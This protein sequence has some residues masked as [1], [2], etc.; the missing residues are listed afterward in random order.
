MSRIGLKTG[1][2]IVLAVLVFCWLIKTPVTAHYWGKRIGI[3]VLLGRVSYWPSRTNMREFR[4]HNPK[5]FKNHTAIQAEQGHIIYRMNYLFSAPSEIDL[6]ELDRVDLN[7]DFTNP[8]GTE[9][10]WTALISKI[11]PRTGTVVIHKFVLTNLTVR[12]TDD[13]TPNFYS[14]VELSEIEGF[15]GFP[16]K[17]LIGE[18]F[19]ATNLNRYL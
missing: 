19:K 11:Q 10:N 14:R 18:L 1:S 17:E 7:V 4:I 6:I 16:T 8:L 15:S 13:S 5:G 9:N 3:P 12:K 2:L